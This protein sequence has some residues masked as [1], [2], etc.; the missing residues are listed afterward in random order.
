MLPS[1]NCKQW[2]YLTEICYI[3]LLLQFLL[4]FL[5]ALAIHEYGFV[6]FATLAFAVLA[7]AHFGV[8]NFVIFAA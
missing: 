4:G 6:K 5:P 1:K 7:S 3:I 8:V 2:K